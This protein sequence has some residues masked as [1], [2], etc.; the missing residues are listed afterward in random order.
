MNH[1]FKGLMLASLAYSCLLSTPV[2]AQSNKSGS[3]PSAEKAAQHKDS[4]VRKVK[5]KKLVRDPNWYYRYKVDVTKDKELRNEGVDLAAMDTRAGSGSHKENLVYT[6]VVV[7]GSVIG[8]KYDD[9]KEVYFHSSYDIKVDEVVAGRVTSSVITVRLRSGKVGESFVNSSEE[10]TL[11]LGEQVLLYLNP[12]DADELA[13]AKAAGQWNYVNNAAPS[14]FS[15]VEKY[16]V[17]ADYVFDSDDKRIEKTAKV[18]SDIKRVSSLLDKEGF[19][20]KAFE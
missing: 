2:Q 19:D 9:R 8:K 20:K 4:F 7:Q 15:L 5:E 3:F 11:Y 13:T 6:A 12:I 16:Y 18:K 10:P 17:K 1:F 14:D